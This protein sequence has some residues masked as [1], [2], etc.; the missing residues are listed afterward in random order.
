MRANRYCLLPRQDRLAGGLPRTT[1]A[2]KVVTAIPEPESEARLRAVA[3]ELAGVALGMV[4][5]P[6][7]GRV[8]VED[9]LTVLAA[10]SGEAVLAAS[11]IIDIESNTMNPGSVILGA[12]INM[13][14]S[15]DVGSYAA[16]PADSVLGVLLVRLVPEFV[17]LEAFGSLE[18]LFKGTMDRI[19]KAPWG[20]IATSL[21]EEHQS[22]IMPLK[23]AFDLRDVVS[24]AQDMVDL[25]IER[26]YLLCV[27]SLAFALEQTRSA[28]EP[29][30]AVTLSLEVLFAMAKRVPVPKSAFS[31][32][33]GTE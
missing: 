28:I 18:T 20:F 4:K 14:L 7:T 8:R 23:A 26:R 29:D 10:A 1:G 16:V 19:E 5:E 24:A 11:G 2:S 22:T 33:A 31:K 32:D 27:Y 13:L 25:P 21:P 12:P 30:I 9:Y 6:E 15:G 17:P 3:Q